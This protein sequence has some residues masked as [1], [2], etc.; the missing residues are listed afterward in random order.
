[1]S[2][3]ER[4]HKSSIVFNEKAGKLIL[5]ISFDT[6]LIDVKYLNFGLQLLEYDAHI[7]ENKSDEG[8]D[9]LS[10]L[11]LQNQ[12]SDNIILIFA[13]IKGTRKGLFLCSGR[14]KYDELI[15]ILQEDAQIKMQQHLLYKSSNVKNDKFKYNISNPKLFIMNK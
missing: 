4:L 12:N 1:M 9:I 3:I 6:I 13:N 2:L 11:Q 10:K 7:I 14:Y 8:R 5:K 15:V